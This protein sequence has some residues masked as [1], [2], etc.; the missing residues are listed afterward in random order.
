MMRALLCGLVLTTLP[1]C[2]AWYDLF[3]RD[4]PRPSLYAEAMALPRPAQT[5]VAIVL[6]CPAVSD[7]RPSPCLR[8]RIRAALHAY[9]TGTVRAAIFAG[10]AAHN[11][12]VE[13]EVMA[14]EALRQGMPASAIFQ[15]PESLTTWQNLR[16]SQ[17]IM[18]EN[19]FQTALLISTR[20]HLPRARR[21]A[22]Y[23]Q[24]PTALWACEDTP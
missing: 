14:T 2:A 19:G 12:F 6:G 9:R 20:D 1:G 13:A 11:R 23:Y 15:E 24:L 3:Q 10:G 7:G 4:K 22:D 5:D 18:K 16:F 8:C 17:R 21:F